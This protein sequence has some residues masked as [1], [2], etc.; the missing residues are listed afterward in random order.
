MVDVFDVSDDESD[1]TES[2]AVA[3][4]KKKKSAGLPDIE[5][6]ETVEILV[7]RYKKALLNRRTQL[8]DVVQR[9][10]DEE[11][12]SHEFLDVYL[13]FA[14]VR[15]VVGWPRNKSCFRQPEG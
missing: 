1:K 14:S 9:L 8:K 3:D 13:V 11:C 7:S 6:E 10:K 12:T 5:G 2:A 15:L 4:T